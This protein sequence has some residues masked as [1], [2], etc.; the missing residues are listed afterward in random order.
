MTNP[1]QLSYGRTAALYRHLSSIAVEFGRPL[2]IGGNHAEKFIPLTILPEDAKRRFP[3]ID[4]AT[5]WF[6][7]GITDYQP[8]PSA[9]GMLC[10]AQF[11][12]FTT[13]DRPKRFTHNAWQLIYSFGYKRPPLDALQVTTHLAGSRNSIA[14]PGPEKLDDA[15]A[16]IMA[17]LYGDERHTELSIPKGT[18]G[19]KKNPMPPVTSREAGQ[20][21][22]MA[23]CVLDILRTQAG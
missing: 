8:A 13:T 23:S 4:D 11:V 10:T 6:R 22:G 12:R 16:R 2:E 18:P 15:A 1:E 5:P 17:A 9:G 14:L 19:T 3:P 7:L 21:M 20:L